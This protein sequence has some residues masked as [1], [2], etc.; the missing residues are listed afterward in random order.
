[1]NN[2]IFNKGINIACWNINGWTVSNSELRKSIINSLNVDIIGLVETHL[3]SDGDNIELPG[4]TWFGNCRK[5]VHI[6]AKKHS[7][8]V[9]FLIKNDLFKDFNIQVLD[10]SFEGII[11]L[12]LEHKCTSFTVVVIVCYLPPEQS[13]WGRDSGDFF[14]NLCTVFS[15]G[16]DADNILITGDF[17][18]RIGDLSD[19]I[20]DVD[21]ITDRIALKSSK[22]IME[23]NLSNFY[24]K[25]KCV[26]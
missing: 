16:I 19:S 7:G 10:K 15:L 21:N 11:A 12:E 9:G 24:L 5:L 1:M 25:P 4:F 18:A 6:K 2:S 13:H 3:P 17:N 20:H 14:A 23:A 22:I 8:G 26:C